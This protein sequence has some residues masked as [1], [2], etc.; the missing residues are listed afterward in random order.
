MIKLF[1][2]N[3]LDIVRP[4]V[5]LKESNAFFSSHPICILGGPQ[6][7][8]VRH[9]SQASEKNRTHGSDR[10]SKSLCFQ[11]YALQNKFISK[12]MEENNCFLKNLFLCKYLYEEH[13]DINNLIFH[14]LSSIP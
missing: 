13:A 11:F 6:L 10:R 9:F 7:R 12:V 14:M 1:F 8:Q 4:K 3:I 5:L 2:F